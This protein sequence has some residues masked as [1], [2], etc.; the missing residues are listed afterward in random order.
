M[1]NVPTQT[2]RPAPNRQRGEVHTD[3]PQPREAGL[4]DVA[5]PLDAADERRQRVGER[6]S[7]SVLKN[8]PMGALGAGRAGP[9][10][11]RG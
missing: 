3:Q 11:S 4:A 10:L 2:R 9:R 6:S 5:V 7:Q 8:S 1:A